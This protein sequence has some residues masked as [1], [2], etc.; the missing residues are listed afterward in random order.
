ME[1]FAVRINREMAEIAKANTKRKGRVDPNDPK[2]RAGDGRPKERVD[3]DGLDNQAGDGRPKMGSTKVPTKSRPGFS[4]E[5]V[6]KE[7]SSRDNFPLASRDEVASAG[8]DDKLN[9]KA[10][11]A[12]LRT[13]PTGAVDGGRRL[14]RCCL[15]A[16]TPRTYRDTPEA[17]PVFYR[18]VQQVPAAQRRPGGQRVGRSATQPQW[19]CWTNFTERS[20]T[21]VKRPEGPRTTSPTRRTTTRTLMMTKTTTGTTRPVTPSSPLSPQRN[22]LDNDTMYDNVSRAALQLDRRRHA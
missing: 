13:R 21:G 8:T 1:A 15:L 5:T 18:A 11:G 7:V 12:A 17:L 3:S 22:G 14:C 6:N 2:E 20:P 4:V 10:A 9:N 19:P 16:E